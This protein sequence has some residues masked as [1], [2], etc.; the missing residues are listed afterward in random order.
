MIEQRFGFRILGSCANER[1]LIDWAAAFAAYAICERRAELQREA[2]LGAFCFGQ[3]FA[4][5]LSMHG[6]TKGY[7]GV[8][9]S[10]FIRWDIDRDGDLQAALDDTR[11]LS[12]LLTER[13]AIADDDLL[14]YFSGSKGFH[15]GLPTAIWSPVPSASFNRVARRFAEG[16]AEYAGI[17]IDT[18]IYDQVRA[19]RAPNSRHPKTGRYK[20]RLS[21]DELLHLSM[22]AILELAS[23]PAPF[24]IPAPTGRCERAAAYWRDA[25]EQVRQHT[26]AMTHRR[27]A[28]NGAATLNQ[29]TLDF[30]RNGAPTGGAGVADDTAGRHR[31][32]FSAAAN[33]REFG[34]PPGL[35]HALLTES[36]L[37]SG[38]SPSDVRRQI[39][40]GLNH[41]GG[42]A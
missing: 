32:L 26:D 25:A 21:F 23:E 13:Y 6:T 30:V 17:A 12:V 3:D 7:R 16:V 20:R 18:S 9:W 27:A 36:A 2:Y 28:A 29:L 39:D 24:D 40:C 33:L 14:T 11:R 15:V 41:E 10:P 31:R 5:Y 4:D 8:C 22:D 38:L 37:D 42:A 1:R 35:A 19:F 34:C